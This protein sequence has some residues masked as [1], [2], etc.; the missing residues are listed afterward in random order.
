MNGEQKKG[1][2]SSY[3]L[4]HVRENQGES[5][6]A[7]PRCRLLLVGVD[8]VGPGVTPGVLTL[9]VR[10]TVRATGAAVRGTR[11]AGGWGSGCV[12]GGLEGCE[13]VAGRGRVHGED[14]STV[15][16]A[17][18]DS[19]LAVNPDGF[20]VEH[21]EG[22]S[23]EVGS[24]IRTDGVESRREANVSDA[25]TTEK[26]R[27]R[28]LESRLRRGV[29]LLAER[30]CNSVANIGAEVGWVVN[31]LATGTDNDVVVRP[32]ERRWERDREESNSGLDHHHHRVV[33]GVVKR[34]RELE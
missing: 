34:E 11:S 22:S 18:G 31:E 5:S 21:S 23:G 30:E 9:G 29:V 3:K 4:Q 12:G 1:V 19:L 27:A 28:G 16:V 32:S 13:G 33:N 10:S 25:I 26:G 8:E 17:D 2:Y 15:A 7:G 14:H 24:Y 6:E 20:G